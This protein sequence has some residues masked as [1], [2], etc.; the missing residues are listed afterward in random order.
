MK[1][2]YSIYTDSERP[3]AERAKALLALMTL[4]EK[5]GQLNQRLYGFNIYKRNGSAIE[6]TEEFRAEVERFGGLGVLY[7]LYRADP[8]ADK[9]EETGITPDIA[10]LAY[11][12]VQ[13]YV[14]EHSRLHIPML[15]S[16]ECPHGHQALDG[17][18]LPVNLCLGACFDPALV[19]RAYK[20]C[21]R[22]LADNKV[23]LALMSV[24]DV[25]RDPRWG[26]SEE[27]YSE[28]PYLA[29]TLAAA[30]VSGMT[31]AGV[32]AVAKHLAAQGETTGGVNA[33]AARIG[34]REL[35]EIHLPTVRAAVK[36]GCGGVMAAYNE[37]DGIYCHANKKLLRDIL[38]GEFGF[39]GTVMADGCALEALNSI[40]GDPAASAALALESGVDISLWDNV[41]TR[42]DE[43]VSSGKISMRRLDEAVLRVL[44]LKFERG[45]FEHPYMEKKPLRLG[46]YGIE[47]ASCAIAREGSV[48]LKNTGVL[49]LREDSRILVTGPNAND[50][51]RQ[52][53][54]YTPPVDR[55]ASFTVLDGIRERF[56]SANVMFAGGCGLFFAEEGEA[57]AAAQAADRADVIIAVLGGSSSRFE[58]VRFD[59]NGAAL[60]EEGIKMDCGEGRDVTDI[61]ISPAQIQLLNRL[62]ES[63]KKIVSIIISGRAYGIAEVLELSDAVIQVFYPGPWGGRAL[64]SL[65]AGDA[66]FSGRLPVSFPKDSGDIPVCYNRR[67]S[68]NGREP[69]LE[70]GFG[71]SYA[72]V[73]Y[74][75][76]ALEGRRL[77]F[78]VRNLSDRE[79]TAVPMLFLRHKGC[80]AVQRVKELKWFDRIPLEPGGERRISVQL[81]ASAFKTYDAQLRYRIEKG[82]SD[83]YLCDGSLR[84][85]GSTVR[86]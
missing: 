72:A 81:P 12:T 14:M 84:A 29:G 75:G 24:L 56:G 49:P 66:D 46:E 9:N 69:L 30:S 27:C 51:Y 13:H 44:T 45:L 8:W 16:S 15:L 53:G 70:F 73:E 37:I 20:E 63:G 52:L 21:G 74:T 65:I 36:A 41:F 17:G 35:R 50:I 22:Q 68:Y 6:L 32:T 47:A 38:R 43:A 61:R 59:R 10:A 80:S 39:E 2:Y 54:D 4:K 19:K 82:T 60:P 33:S 71:L 48:L 11:N 55:A 5:V 57:E 31:S 34:E 23:D 62:K 1:D 18:L 3:A 76:C 85:Q 58:S 28:D 79:T 86:V 83:W 42:L 7:G 25:C 40:T 78:T 64:A 77:S 67:A 26:R